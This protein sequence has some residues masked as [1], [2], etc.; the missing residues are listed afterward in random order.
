MTTPAAWVEVLRGIPSR[1]LAVSSSVRTLGLSS[2]MV[3]SWAEVFSAS[4]SV[5]WGVAGT[6]LATTSVSA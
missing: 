3:L 4:S 2:Y 6:S 1:L 5:I